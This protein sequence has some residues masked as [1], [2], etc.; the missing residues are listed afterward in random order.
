MVEAAAV[1]YVPY[2]SLSTIWGFFEPVS[3]HEGRL[4]VSWS[5]SRSLGVWVAGGVRS[6]GDTETPVVITPRSTC[7]R[8]RTEFS[9]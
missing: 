3:Y 2:F 4:R 8:V 1:R 9:S 5:G 7:V 6:Y